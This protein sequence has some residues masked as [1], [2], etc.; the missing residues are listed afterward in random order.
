MEGNTQTLQTMMTFWMD[1]DFS[2]TFM[3]DSAE[4]VRNIVWY[5]AISGFAINLAILGGRI[6]W[7]RRQGLADGLEDVGSMF[8]NIGLYG[9]VVP[10]GIFSAVALGDALSRAILDEFGATDGATFL[11]GTTLEESTMG[12]ILM[13][14]L[15]GVSLLG[16]LTQ[17]LAMVARTLLLP[18]IVGLLPMFAGLTATEWGKGA[19]N[20]MKYWVVALIAFKPLAA[21]IYA[22]AFWI[23]NREGN[24]DDLMWT[25]TKVL[26]VAIAGFSVVGIAKIIL[27]AISS[28]GGSNTAAV[29]AAAAGATGAV[30]AG[31]M[32]M[33]GGAA[34][35]AGKAL[36]GKA[37]SGAAKGG[38]AGS[39]G[40]PGASGS[41]G[42][43]GTGGGGPPGGDGGAG[44]TQAPDTGGTAKGSGNTTGTTTGSSSSSAPPQK[45]R[46]GRGR[47]IAQGAGTA[48][49]AM[50]GGAKIAARTTRNTSRGVA[51]QLPVMQNAS[52]DSLGSAGHPGQ[53]TR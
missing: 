35:M 16:S 44:S 25:V 1:M 21:I 9:V 27:P 34:G 22:V 26:V 51:A 46:A 23:S 10:G 40:S 17:L 8:W 15:V 41:A 20:S 7:N 24:E 42:P 53:V 33:V 37:A 36:G 4:G 3:Q 14:V 2:Q 32:S 28:M 47:R 12:P 49:N 39:G 43:P 6:A 18:I 29:G 13:L 45:A 19:L 38:S 50:S 31:A 48:L 30:A 11:E 52:D 5:L